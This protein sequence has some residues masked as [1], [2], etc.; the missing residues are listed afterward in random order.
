[1]YLTKELRLEFNSLYN[2]RPANRVKR[3]YEI[4]LLATIV[5]RLAALKE[6]SL[7]SHILHIITMFDNKSVCFKPTLTT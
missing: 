2:K 4:L 7:G 3:L 1:M 5:L 6:I